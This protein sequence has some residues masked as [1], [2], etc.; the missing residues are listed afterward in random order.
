MDTNETRDISSKET[1]E[2]TAAIGRAVRGA[3]LKMKSRDQ[4]RR[5]A[6]VLRR[7]LKRLGAKGV[8]CRVNG[9]SSV[10]VEYRL[11]ACPIEV[12]LEDG[13]EI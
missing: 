2:L 13:G 3:T 9:R 4:I 11:P 1:E 12:K 6:R 8:K 7:Y 5:D 10:D